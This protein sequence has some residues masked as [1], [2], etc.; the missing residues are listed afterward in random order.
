MNKTI[1]INL[2]GTNF[3]IEEDAYKKLDE[4]LSSI[5]A[6]FA[7]YPGSEEI[8]QDMENRIA[9]KFSEQHQ[10]NTQA[11]ITLSDAEKLIQ[12][13]GSVEDI[14]GQDSGKRS[15]EKT[16]FAPKKLMRDGSNKVI[17]GVASGIA[18]YFD[19]DPFWVRLGFVV[20]LFAWGT[21]IPIYLVLWLIMPEAKTP[22][23]KM[24]MRG[25][26]LNL[27]SIG[28]TI[29]ERAH[30]FEEH[31]KKKRVGGSLNEF[32]SRVGE[33]LKRLLSI[34]VKVLSFLLVVGF[35]FATALFT[36][37]F[38]SLL[39]N[40]NSPYIGFPLSTIAHGAGFH[41]LLVIA[42]ALV[43]VPLIFLLLLFV[44]LFSKRKIVSST[45]GF[46]LFGVWL[47]ALVF[48]GVLGS[49][50]IP[51]YVQQVKNSPELQTVSKTFD[52]R[53]FKRIDVSNS[54]DYKLVEGNEFKIRG[55]GWAMDVDR[56][57]VTQEGDLLKITKKSEG[58]CFFCI[59]G[60]TLVEITAPFFEEIT[61]RNSSNV[62]SAS[63]TATTTTINLSNSASA[64]FTFKGQTLNA[65]LL[66]S[67]FFKVA[68]EAQNFN[69]TLQN[70]SNLDSRALK[71]A[72]ANITAGNSS[73]ANVWVTDVLKYRIFNAGRINYIGDPA[74][75]GD[76]SRVPRK[77]NSLEYFEDYEIDPI[78]PVAPTAP[79]PQM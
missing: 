61:A 79:Q 49:R 6:H 74:L 50:Y 24:Q 56:L 5:R 51:G 62:Q 66:N 63:L 1:S 35:A 76:E 33:I 42:Y 13:L 34:L 69:A 72:N 46:S 17:A 58:H 73:H 70:A 64:G 21:M 65:N 9:E 12:E 20:L 39:F 43:I 2:G 71:A 14:T 55:Q 38:V 48:A 37:A 15:E 44:A 41:F 78:K 19:I 11:V 57:E 3:F 60:D 36:T 32:F 16:S 59:S 30:E 67:S 52:H 47:I 18:A 77:D 25:E 4:Y 40:V 23:E 45:V 75:E 22:T 53:D 26:P 27:D 28:Q 7:R 54:I 29:K 68:G 8:V 10:G 31:V